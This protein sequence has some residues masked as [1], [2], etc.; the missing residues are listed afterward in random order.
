MEKTRYAVTLDLYIWADN[1]EQAVKEAQ[2][3]AADMDKK[4]DNK[5]SVVN[6]YE[7]PFG[8]GS[9]EVTIR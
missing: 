3:I 5:C 6:V 4:D 1:D 2:Q 8:F 7:T 9:R